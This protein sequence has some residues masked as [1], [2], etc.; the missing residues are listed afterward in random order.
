M[1]R[2]HLA[3][4]IVG[5]AGGDER[6]R[7]HCRFDDD[8]AMHQAG[9]DPVSPRKILFSRLEARRPLRDET[10]F[11]AD[12]ALKL[13]VL[14]RINPSMPPARTATVPRANAAS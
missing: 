6:S 11:A 12:P 8:D 5:I 13:G 14:G 2:E 1:K 4:E 10:A 9:N 3:S 7:S